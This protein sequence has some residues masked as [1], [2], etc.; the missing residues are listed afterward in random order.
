MPTP[1]FAPEDVLSRLQG[2]AMRSEL[3]RFITPRQL[4]TALREKK[5]L[6]LRR[7]RY[8]LP[9]LP[10]PEALAIAS[11]GA[12]SYQT[13]AI[14]IGWETL[15]QPDTNHLSIAANGRAGSRHRQVR[16]HYT[17]SSD[18]SDVDRY[19]ALTVTTPLKTVLDCAAT[20][21]LDQALAIADSALR[22]GLDPDELRCAAGC[23]AGNG[24]ANVRL[25]G[26]HACLNAA[27]VFESALRAI[28]I[29]TG[30]PGFQPQLRITA[31]SQTYRVDLADPERRIVLEADSFEWHGSRKALHR[32]C[33]R[34][35]ELVRNGWLV[36]R[37]SWESV[38][39]DQEWVGSVI[40]DV[41]KLREPARGGRTGRAA[42]RKPA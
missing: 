42:G 18:G 25:V 21:P 7:G 17:L 10:D 40:R 37:F 1:R 12:L 13:A 39:F 29:R 35:D 30:I 4:D 15:R 2:A 34:Y 33:R 26:R 3:I 16:W 24:A 27:N 6:R 23:F 28:C 19:G 5:I 38:M 22:H 8:A 41:A 11:G 31:G 36:L 20:L 9:D 14:W 32:D